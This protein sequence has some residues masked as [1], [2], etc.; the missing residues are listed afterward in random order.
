[1]KILPKHGLHGNSLKKLFDTPPA[2]QRIDLQMKLLSQK[3]GE[4]ED[5]LEYISRVKNIHLDIIKGGY[6]KLEDS[7]LIS[8]LINGLPKSYW[9]FIETLQIADKLTSATFDS[10]S[11]MLT[12]HSKT[13]GK[14]KQSGEDVLFTSSSKGENSRGRGRGR[15]QSSFRGRGRGRSQGR[16]NNFQGSNFQQWS[17]SLRSI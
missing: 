13:F 7:F 17:N 5:V 14:Q 2:S 12:Q 15:N 1:M 16:S 9:K 6:G 4:K 3:L 8:I 11:E 10:F